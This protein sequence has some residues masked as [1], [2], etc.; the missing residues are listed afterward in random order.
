MTEATWDRIRCVA[1]DYAYTLCSDHY[2]KELGPDF[3]GLVHREIFN[4]NTP[5]WCDPWLRGELTAEDIV[6][7]LAAF[8]GISHAHIMAQL[9]QG[10]AH[11]TMHPAIWQF[12][13]AQR[14]QGRKTA[15]VTLNM[16]IFSQVVV[17]SMGFDYV[18]DVIVNSADH[19]HDDKMML[20]EYAF[21]QLD[22]CDFAN[23]LL[24]DDNAKY[25]EY[26]R[27]HGGM[28]YQYTGDE[29]FARWLKGGGG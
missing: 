25:V 29:D 15:L 12:A 21:S 27:A 17:P 20:W 13:Q 2:F 24:I 8:S 6:A 18:F 7:H 28:A 3:D 23:S 22:G 16:D 11:Q 19:R 10:C 26:F 1:F 5:K 14:A 9:R 4:D